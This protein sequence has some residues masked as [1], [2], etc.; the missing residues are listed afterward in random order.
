MHL[1]PPPDAGVDPALLSA[2]GALV[3]RSMDAHPSPPPPPHLRADPYPLRRSVD[4]GSLSR[5][6]QVGL[7]GFYFP[8]AGGF[9]PPHA[10][11][12]HSGP[13]AGGL[14]AAAGLTGGGGGPAPA[15]GLLDRTAALGG[16]SP[17]AQF[18]TLHQ[19]RLRGLAPD[20]SFLPPPAAA[21]AAFGGA[22]GADRRAFLRSIDELRC[23]E[24]DDSS[25]ASASVAKTESRG[26]SF[27]GEGVER[28]KDGAAAAH[29]AAGFPRAF[30]FDK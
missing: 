21:A 16:P 18:M 11:P 25:A 13:C 12:G 15:A 8:A 26:S 19:D 24:D 30:S 7:G 27:D 17:A 9:A 29:R 1:L 28:G 20:G 4:L 22:D 5:S 3:R 2:L 10:Y 23:S 6:G 14:S